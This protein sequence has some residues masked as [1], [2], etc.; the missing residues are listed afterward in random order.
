[1]GDL[2]LADRLRLIR[3]EIM[4][5]R[6]PHWMVAALENAITLVDSPPGQ[7]KFDAVTDESCAEVTAY[8][9]AFDLLD[10]GA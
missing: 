1:M 5:Q 6:L 3:F 10:H 2:V 8:Y 7:T 4:L 9:R